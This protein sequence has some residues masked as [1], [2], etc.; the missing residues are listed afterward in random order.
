[1][2]IINVN[3]MIKSNNIILPINTYIIISKI[4]NIN[5][6]MYNKIIWFL[7]DSV[8]GFTS[9]LYLLTGIKLYKL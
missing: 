2:V 9:G 6:N 5:E 1:M 3:V 8:R 7:C 4:T